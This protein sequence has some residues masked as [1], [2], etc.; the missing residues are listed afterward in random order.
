MAARVGKTI[1]SASILIVIEHCVTDLFSFFMRPP[2]L[3]WCHVILIF[4]PPFFFSFS[5]SDLILV[6]TNTCPIDLSPVCKNGLRMLLLFVFIMLAYRWQ[7]ICNYYYCLVLFNTSIKHW[8][9]QRH[10]NRKLF[11]C[12]WQSYVGFGCKLFQ[13]TSGARL[14]MELRK[15]KTMMKRKCFIANITICTQLN[16]HYTK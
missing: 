11:R 7:P 8:S 5:N 6:Y 16:I 12:F 13:L 4:V 2:D 9:N 1:T 14:Q 10:F 3:Y 15:E